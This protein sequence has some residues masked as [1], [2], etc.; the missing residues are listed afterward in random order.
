M[1]KIIIR[2]RPH[3]ALFLHRHAGEQLSGEFAENMKEIYERLNSGER[4]MVQIIMHRDTLCRAC[5]HEKDAACREEEKVLALDREIAARCSLRSGQ[6]LSWEEL[7][8]ILQNNG[9]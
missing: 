5:P 6:W 8:D 3:H 2:L 7:R 9:Y 4:E 1:E